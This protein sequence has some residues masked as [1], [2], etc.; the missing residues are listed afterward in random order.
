MKEFDT[1]RQILW[2]LR[3]VNIRPI[4]FLI[5]IIFALLG[6]ALDGIGMGL[7]IPMLEG[8]LSM[9]YSF[10]KETP[11][12][13]ILIH[14][15]PQW[16]LADRWL[17]IV[18]IT[19]FSIVILLKNV[20][21]YV[22]GISQAYL[23]LRARHHL[24]KILF[25]RTT[26]FGKL[27]FDRTSVGRLSS[28][29]STLTSG[30]LA[31]IV[32]L[33]QYASALFSLIAYLVV[34]V[35]ISWKITIIALGLFFVLHIAVQT[36]VTRIR[37]LSQAMTE[38]LQELNHRT[39]EIISL[40]PLVKASNMERVEREQYTDISDEQTKLDF[41][42]RAFKQII[43]P[44]HEI[45]ALFAILTLLAG[46]LYLMALRGEGAPTAFLVYFYLVINAISRFGTIMSFRGS[47]A[48]AHGPLEKVLSLFEDDD[49]HHVPDG[50]KSFKKLQKGISLRNLSFQYT[51]GISALQGVSFMVKKGESTA[52]VGP[53]GAGKSTIISLLLRYYDC[54]SGTIFVD[55]IDIRDFTA[56]SLREQIALVSQDIFLLNDT[57]RKNILYGRHNVA[58]DTLWAAITKAR[59]KEVIQK[60]P[61]GLE[62]RIGDRGVKL[63]GGEKQRV[64]LARAILRD[65][66][67]IILDEATSS[68]D[69]KTEKQ[70]QEAIQETI[71]GK[72]AIAIAHRLSTIQNANQ[73][74]VLQEGKCV[75]TGTFDQLIEQ[76]GA[77][78]ELWQEQQ[79]R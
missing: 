36:I 33:N 75:E 4:F 37:A 70:I 56:A 44:L 48:T 6:A 38:R 78:F 76:K 58:D 22:A 10:L 15:L 13:N 54:P 72:T 5:P 11:V 14:S 68:L 29:L 12:I 2:L 55:D 71:A 8:F 79:F 39:I 19:I 53:T 34:M 1:V 59:L 50:A 35:F 16:M 47:L 51:E 20:L 40:I 49:K 65:A 73:I 42:S 45:F 17:F 31:P 30:A 27:Y 52:I 25:E 66:D 69:S 23:G 74:V 43:R 63:S 46:M 60:L 62:T 24:R 28:I 77:F 32:N 7:L 67:I 57:L 9:D 18:L 3:R 26:Y 64:A 61:Q 41:R 21:R